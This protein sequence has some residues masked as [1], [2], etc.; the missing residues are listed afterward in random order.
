MV[1]MA[2]FRGFLQRPLNTGNTGAILKVVD[3]LTNQERQSAK[4]F[5]DQTVLI[6]EKHQ[7][8]QAAHRYLLG[9]TGVTSVQTICTVENCPDVTD[10]L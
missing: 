9:L 2:N 6:I 10:G 7:N 4:S 1:Q 3:S 5:P 8:S